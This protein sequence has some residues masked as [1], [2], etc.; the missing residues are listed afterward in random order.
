M[1][2]CKTCNQLRTLEEFQGDFKRYDEYLYNEIFKKELFA[3]NFFF[4]NKQVRFKRYPIE[5]HRE[6]A[7]FHLTTKAASKD[8][9]MSEREPDLRRCERLHWLRPSIEK[10]HIEFCGLS[11]F[12][13]YEEPSKRGKTRINLFNEKERYLIILE[14]RNDYFL[15][16][17]A[18]YIHEE[19]YLKSTKKRSEKAKQ[20]SWI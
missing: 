10:N 15:L 4:N 17:T 6:Q 20:Y 7:Y 2:S 18:F 5:C 11:C 13:Y 3:P 12:V 1:K 8:I 19:H 14:D 16:V 9:P